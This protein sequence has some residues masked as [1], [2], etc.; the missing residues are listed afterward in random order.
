MSTHGIYLPDL[1][2]P[3]VL[4]HVSFE[5][6]YADAC[7]QFN[8]YQPLAFDINKRPVLT[9]A[10]LVETPSGEKYFKVPADEMQG[11]FYVGLES[12][13]QSRQFMVM[14]YREMGLRQRV[15]DSCL[16]VIPAYAKGADLDA[17]ADRY[18]LRRHVITPE[19]DKLPAVM[20]K[21]S[22]LLR[23]I[24]LAYD[25]NT[26]AGSEQSYVFH[27]LNA[28]GLVKDIYTYSPEPCVSEVYVL[29]HEAG[30][31]PSADLLA[32]VKAALNVKYVR[33]NSEDIEVF[34]GEVI[35][36]EI[37]GTATFAPGP[38]AEPLIEAAIARTE[39]W[40]FDNFMLGRDVTESA[41]HSQLHLS[42]VVPGMHEVVLDME[43]PIRCEPHQAARCTG[44]YLS[45]GGRNV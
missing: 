43:L 26:T 40:A 27:G 39:T 15:N 14:A 16:A 17:I 45:N 5:D 2:K 31:V 44:V 23:R 11:L 29:S 33:P 38:A 30:G 12:D 25:G 34:A 7:N 19:T 42:E 4:E 1:P 3:D 32:K 9:E 8:G 20:E 18:Q 36:Y 13:P 35:E 6:I 21:D 24:S 10:E 41:V 37:R 28:D 22:D